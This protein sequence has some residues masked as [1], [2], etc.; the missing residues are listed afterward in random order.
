MKPKISTML[1]NLLCTTPQKRE[2]SQI[3][4]IVYERGGTTINLT[5][6]KMIVREYY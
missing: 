3:C 1:T 6:M 2:T 4:K 5:E